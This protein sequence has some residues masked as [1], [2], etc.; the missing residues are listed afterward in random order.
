MQQRER[1]RKTT[2][3]MM[4]MTRR[5]ASSYKHKKYKTRTTKIKIMMTRR[6]T[7]S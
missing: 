3:N 4:T 5:V 7:N 1:R 6:I 2:I